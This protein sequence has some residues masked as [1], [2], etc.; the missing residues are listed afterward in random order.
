LELSGANKKAIYLL[1]IAVL[2]AALFAF[3]FFGEKTPENPISEDCSSRIEEETVNGTSLSGLVENGETVF[4]HY[5]YFK[6]KEMKRGDI[7]AYSYAGRNN[8]IIKIIKGIP[9][10]KFKL[11]AEKERWKIL[12]NG[13]PAKNSKGE[14]YSLGERAY[15][16][17]SLYEKDYGGEIPPGA[18]LL[19]GNLAYGTLDSTHFGPVSGDDILG[20][21]L[22]Y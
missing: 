16:M 6:C 5:G 3:S 11:R 9:G 10:D 15:N 17:L 1:L 18:Y 21:I 13:E 7:V 12:I 20:A 4:L 14:E 22:P 19:F 2:A 8:P